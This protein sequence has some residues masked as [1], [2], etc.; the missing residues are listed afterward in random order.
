MESIA[1]VLG[2]YCLLTWGFIIIVSASIAYHRGY[3]PGPWLLWGFLF[4][5][6][7][8]IAIGLHP[9]RDDRETD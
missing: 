8:L 6:L 5:P 7:A 1:L 4:G 3:D 9:V 2:I